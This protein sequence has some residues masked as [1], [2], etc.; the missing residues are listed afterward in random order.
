MKAVKRIA[1][2]FLYGIASFICS[3]SSVAI[4]LALSLKDAN[5]PE[6]EPGLF[7]LPPPELIQFIFICPL[8]HLSGL[9][10][11]VASFGLQPNANGIGL[12]AMIV[13]LL[14]LLF[15]LFVWLRWTS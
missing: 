1:P 9:L 12:W 4:V 11:G 2:H 10:L 6:T 13:S 5:Q 14:L 7:D 8:I 3:V 15:D